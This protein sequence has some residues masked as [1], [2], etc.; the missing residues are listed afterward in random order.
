MHKIH[1]LELSYHGSVYNMPPLCLK[2]QTNRILNEIYC[3]QQFIF[4]KQGQHCIFFIL[5]KRIIERKILP[6]LKV[7]TT[8]DL[9]EATLI[10]K[11]FKM[12]E[13]DVWEIDVK[14]ITVG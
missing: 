3:T 8:Y 14:V 5:R 12:I 2:W 1:R 9:K 11:Q 13:Y 4:L 7:S 6:G 10:I